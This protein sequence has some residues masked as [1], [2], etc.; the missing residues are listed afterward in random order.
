MIVNE[1]SF[2][3]ITGRSPGK[4]ITYDK[5]NINYINFEVMDVI[6]SMRNITDIIYGNNSKKHWYLSRTISNRTLLFLKS[7]CLV[8]ADLNNL[9][10]TIWMYSTTYCNTIVN[11]YILDSEYYSRDSLSEYGYVFDYIKGNYINLFII[12]ELCNSDDGFYDFFALAYQLTQKI[13]IDTSGLEEYN[14]SGNNQDVLIAVGDELRPYYKKMNSIFATW[15]YINIV[16]NMIVW[17]GYD[18]CTE[19]MIEK[20][21]DSPITI[22]KNIIEEIIKFLKSD[23]FHLDSFDLLSEIDNEKVQNIIEMVEGDLYYA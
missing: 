3:E 10:D 18:V 2:R 14:N 19:I 17:F 22:P 11:I 20:D 13:I 21:I 15:Y 5:A 12:D 1:K 16:F 8:D 9:E 4:L 6:G 7:I 23:N